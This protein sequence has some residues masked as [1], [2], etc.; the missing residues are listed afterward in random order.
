M[1]LILTSALAFFISFCFAQ[2]QTTTWTGGAGTNVWTDALNWNNGIPT[3]TSDAIIAPAGMQPIINTN[4]NLNSLAIQTSASLTV[5]STGALNITADVS[6]QGS[7]SLA[8]DAN[9]MTVGG[10]FNNSGVW[11]LGA[12]RT[13]FLAGHFTNT[14][15][16]TLDATSLFSLNGTTNTNFSGTCV[17]ANLTI[18]KS[19]GAQANINQNVTVNN[20][21]VITPAAILT[22]NNSQTLRLAGN[23]TNS[24]TFTNNT[25]SIV[26]LIGTNTQTLIGVLS[27]QTLTISK[28]SGN[29]NI[30]VV[31]SACIFSLAN[32]LTIPTG[33]NVVAGNAATTLNFAQNLVADGSF[34]AQTGITTTFSGTTNSSISGTGAVNLSTTIIAKSGATN[35]LAIARTVIVSG[36]L[37]VN[38][39]AEIVLNSGQTL[40]VSGNITITGT[41]TF[42]PQ[43][44]CVL[45]LIGTNTQ[46]VVGTIGTILTPLPTLT[47]SK[48]SGTIN[49]G[50]A[51]IAVVS[52]A[53]TLTIPNSVSVILDN[54]NT[55]LNLFADL[56]VDGTF[57][58]VNTP[59]V[60]FLGNT[61]ANVS[62]TGATCIF[63]TLRLGKTTGTVSIARTCTINSNLFINASNTLDL[64][65]AGTVTI[66]GSITQN[67]VITASIGNT[68]A[69]AAGNIIT[70]TGTGT[71][72]FRNLAFTKTGNP[73]TISKA[74]TVNG[75][76]TI[77]NIGT[78]T[79]TF[80][81]TAPIFNGN[82]TNSGT[83]TVNLNVASTIAG[84]YLHSGTGTVNINAT[85]TL[86]G[87]FT[88]S[89]TGTTALACNLTLNNGA[90]I[91]SGNVT[92]ANTFMLNIMGN[93][94]VSGG[95][96]TANPTSTTR[97]SG[98]GN[99]V[100]SGAGTININQIDLN[101]TTGT[102]QIDN[103]VTITGN[104]TVPAG[105]TLLGNTSSNIQLGGSFTNSGTFTPIN[106]STVTFVGTTIIGFTP[107]TSTF[108]NLVVNKTGAG[109]VQI[110]QT[111]T[112]NGSVTLAAGTLTIESA[113]NLQIAEN[114]MQNGGT[115]NPFATT[116]TVTFTGTGTN[117]I[118][119]TNNTTFQTLVLNKTSGQLTID[120]NP[121][122]V[123]QNFT[124]PAGVTL[125]INPS[126]N[127][128]F[129][130]NLAYEGTVNT[131]SG[132]IIFNGASN[133]TLTRT[134]GGNMVFR[135]FIN[136]K[137]AG[138]K[139]TLQNNT[140][141]GSWFLNN[142][143][144]LELNSSITLTIGT[145]F[146]SGAYWQNDG[147]FTSNNATVEIQGTNAYNIQGASTID[148]YNLRMNTTG[149][150][151]NLQ[152]LVSVTNQLQL[153]SG[154]ITT[155]GTNV[156][157]LASTAS[158]HPTD[159]G[160]NASH[161]SG[162]MRKD[163]ATNFIFPT[164][165]GGRL[166]RIAINGL[167]ATGN[168]TAE[169]FSVLFGNS[170]I[171]FTQATPL[172]NVSDKE[173]WRLIQT[174]TVSANVTLYWNDDAAAAT[175]GINLLTDA[176]IPNLQIARWQT[177]S[178]KWV[179]TGGTA[180]T[181]ASTKITQ[182][183]LANAPAVAPLTTDDYFCIG[184]KTVNNL[185]WGLLTWTG[186]IDT[187]WL[188]TNNWSPRTTPDFTAPD[189]R[190]YNIRIPDDRP[191]Y[192]II[193]TGQ[194]IDI[195]TLNLPYNI[196]PTPA[197]PPISST[198]T[199]NSGGA[200][201]VGTGA[202]DG[203]LDISGTVTNNG[204]LTTTGATRINDS[205]LFINAAGTATLGTDAG[206]VT[207][208]VSGTIAGTSEFRVTSGTVNLG[209]TTATITNRSLIT[210]KA[211]AVVNI[212]GTGILNVRNN[213]IL[214]LNT[215]L[216][217]AATL[218]IG[219]NTA[220]GTVTNG[221]TITN[222]GIWVNT[223][224][225]FNN[226]TFNNTSSA[227]IAGLAS[228]IAVYF[229]NGATA[230]GTLTNSGTFTLRGTLRST[231][232]G[233][234]ITNSAIFI[235]NLGDML[236]SNNTSFTQ[237]AGTTTVQRNITLSNAAS[238]TNASGSIIT[239]TQDLVLGNGTTTINNGTIN[240]ARNFTNSNTSVT[241][242][243]TGTGTI[244]LTGTDD[245]AL[246][247]GSGVD[248]FF[249]HQLG[250]SKTAGTVTVWRSSTF[251][252]AVT[253]P[254]AV[255]LTISNGALNNISHTFIDN[256]TVNGTW[257]TGTAST[258]SNITLRGD[259][260]NNG[261]VIATGS[262]ITFGGTTNGQLLG[263][264][265]TT[266]LN[267][268]IV[269]KTG[270]ANFT[271][272]H[273]LTTNGNFTNTAGTTNLNGTRTLSV[274]GIFANSATFNAL[275]NA[276]IRLNNDF[277]NN[278]TLNADTDSEFIFLGGNT[279][280][281]GSA[282]VT[283]GKF[284]LNKTAGTSLTLNRQATIANALMLTEG[285]L[286]SSSTNLL[287][288]QSNATASAGKATS[289]VNGPLRKFA[290]SA[291]FNFPVGKGGRWARIGLKDMTDVNPTDYFTAEYFSGFN[292]TCGAASDIQ[293]VVNP[294]KEVSI[295]EHWVLDKGTAGTTKARV[296][297]YWESG[298]FSRITFLGEDLMIGRC[299][300]LF[301]EGRT[302]TVEA[303]STV[304]SGAITTTDLQAS[305]SPWTFA[306]QSQQGVN[307][308]PIT[309]KEFTAKATDKQAVQL[310]WLTIQENNFQHFEVERSQN[311][312][313][314]EPLGMV[315]ATGN[316]NT[317]NAY[318]WLDEKPYKGINY[319]RL[320][321]V[322]KNGAFTFSPTI[323][324]RIEAAASSLAN[325]G[326]YPNPI[327]T[328]EKLH[329][330][331]P[332]TPHTITLSDIQ[333][334]VLLK[335]MPS[336]LDNL[337]AGVYLLRI[338]SD[339]E[340]IIKRIV[341]Q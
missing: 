108:H 172:V 38:T 338:T 204:T 286:N 262:R 237:T 190:Y 76:T 174:G 171:D 162:A 149:G 327:K 130:R 247:G 294:V 318:T 93:V 336:D 37:T 226:G 333:G 334:K 325:I 57:N 68:F 227:N 281:G 167:S 74:L 319:Y 282:G 85:P 287:I 52:L 21:L 123:Q 120:Q 35:D 134:T 116:S 28:T 240:I 257:N 26:E 198:L 79:I 305:F 245:S 144:E 161:V 25:N 203:T 285:F 49:I 43:A 326:I 296:T 131:S 248:N 277:T 222:N 251:T 323:A 313:T 104:L 179:N 292:T 185:D 288:L 312:L 4:I 310:N 48:A 311:A 137:T 78:P 188:N 212:S 143:G 208:G 140:L 278:G 267:E 224:A 107:T 266:T 258:T 56:V 127:V 117:I 207:V 10:V 148:I 141:V 322:D 331:L 82:F 126:R 99:H 181:A 84:N 65:V 244:N 124:L 95:T 157:R 59:E 24:G 268:V 232:A 182:G 339:S 5:N 340:T 44:S 177:S 328:G 100:I 330:N 40:Q 274:A 321:M 150:S 233:S 223:M 156:L 119:G 60:Y 256:L 92:L 81:T 337:P 252:N 259:L 46:A 98:T 58:R 70:V 184:I 154:V 293:N 136:Q 173:Y 7:F 97:F 220:S 47:I 34:T 1:K 228:M 102:L 238:L 307:P 236:F 75:N 205:G 196:D 77:N 110:N 61:N 71:T 213:L 27:L 62:G 315:E 192:P 221:G 160:S 314:F 216:T 317:A 197:N 270:G 211:N 18:S 90:T 269:N 106:P 335:T 133:S 129:Q 239:S 217:N 193:T 260:V 159:A 42:T 45:E 31:G 289:Y 132:G 276:Q 199:I 195:R 275:A 105:V 114:F 89:G 306:S 169:Y 249:S 241:L 138:F 14:G 139:T 175:S 308:L 63:P 290:G 231:F 320:R 87:T 2:A 291:N 210:Q 96:Y 271:I 265:L 254:N 13:L 246:S 332:T 273:N 94:T 29:V 186:D 11:S 229:T 53:N 272:D 23:V 50:N 142:S 243:F 54:S 15:T 329:I 178:D 55:D 255:T 19:G 304:A 20:D 67:G 297:L 109:E 125:A 202:A 158:T 103:V 234:A 91:S 41:G 283:F 300:G 153:T 113:Q 6:N 72:N 253:V 206:D 9:N 164:G 16:L 30:G 3:I 215:S 86:T 128:A 324:V 284:T 189:N 309:L 36:N 22:I 250:I 279:T 302:K 303:G 101:K 155:A 152:R 170:S 88:H 209:K 118:G 122:T 201:N 69:I 166:G 261:T 168:F 225:F 135:D 194:T 32:S 115:F 219:V 263:S 341:K 73:C 121:P 165:K 145:M 295:Y 146:F 147:V 17:F 112:T 66:F 242:N 51:G 191:N 230:I 218:T 111:V 299:N 264:I 183:N 39:G 214:A 33:V 83:G 163:G 301:W 187:Q 151:A 64:T 298:T 235:L 8:T 176:N 12:N 316:Q 80:N 200:L 280:I 180:H